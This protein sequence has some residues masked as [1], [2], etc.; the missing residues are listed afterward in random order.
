[1]VSRL[2]LQLH[3]AIRPWAEWRWKMVE[4]GIGS[5]LVRWMTAHCFVPG[6]KKYR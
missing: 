1:M 3:L 4:V 2:H 6:R 5:R